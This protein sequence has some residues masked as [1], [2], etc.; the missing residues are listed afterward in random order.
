MHLTS[1]LS[2]DENEK[3]FDDLEELIESTYKSNND[4]PVIILCHSMGC[5]YSL[6]FFERQPREWKEQYLRSFIT[7]AAPFGGATESLLSIL[8]GYN[9]D[10]PFYDVRE[11]RKMQQTFTSLTFLLPNPQI[12]GNTTI[13]SHNGRNYTASEIDD[14]LTLANNTNLHKMWLTTRNSLSY[15][16]PGIET[17]CVYGREVNTHA[18]TVYDDESAFPDKP[19]IITGDGDGTVNTLSAAA[20]GKWRQ[21]SEENSFNFTLTEFE[22]IRHPDMIRNKKVVDHVTSII[23]NLK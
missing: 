3:Y 12:F 5:L 14:I 18:V 4:T 8:S 21:S 17:H 2:T 19:F 9:F 15:A 6:Y 11:F 16:H 10:V 13:L 20:C 23:S 7:V 22:G 1:L